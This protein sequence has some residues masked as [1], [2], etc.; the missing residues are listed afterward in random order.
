MAYHHVFAEQKTV[1]A[2]C[3]ASS[4]ISCLSCLFSLGGVQVWEQ[5]NYMI[6]MDMD[7]QIGYVHYLLSLSLYNYVCVKSGD[8]IKHSKPASCR[9]FPQRQSS[10][11]KAK[12][13]DTGYHWVGCYSNKC[14][15]LC[16]RDQD[17]H[18]CPAKLM[19]SQHAMKLVGKLDPI[20]RNKLVLQC[21][22]TLQKSNISWKILKLND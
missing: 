6:D 9:P 21:S 12:T 1:D 3:C 11:I 17:Y 22:T 19:H 2:C 13:T 10:H 18:F 15:S 8:T 4:P 14:T 20:Y 7:S 16:K 5:I